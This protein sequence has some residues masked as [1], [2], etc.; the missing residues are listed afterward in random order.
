MICYYA[1]LFASLPGMGME[2][3]GV[4][5]ICEFRRVIVVS[6][7]LFRCVSVRMSQHTECRTVS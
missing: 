1:F 3:G 4:S 5:A 6:F 7:S 2:Y